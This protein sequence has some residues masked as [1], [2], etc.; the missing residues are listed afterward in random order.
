MWKGQ[1]DF[2]QECLEEKRNDLQ[3]VEGTRAINQVCLE[4]KRND[5]Q[6]VWQGKG[7][8]YQGCQEEE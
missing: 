7:V 2:Y 6:S 5:L 4:K 8:I 1:G 3:C